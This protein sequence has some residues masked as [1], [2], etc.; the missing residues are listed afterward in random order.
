MAARGFETARLK[1]L[2]IEAPEGLEDGLRALLTSKVLAP[3]PPSFSQNVDRPLDWLAARLAE[4]A[5][6]Q[7]LSGNDLIGLMILADKDP[8]EIHVGYLFR[9]ASWGQGFASELVLGLVASLGE[10]LT[11]RAGV[12]ADNPASLRV[13]EKAGFVVSGHDPAGGF[14]CVRWAGGGTA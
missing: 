3:L 4:S 9:E 2:P 1:I 13:L 14:Q 8:G 6:Y 10:A 11:L 12:E 5:V 7:V